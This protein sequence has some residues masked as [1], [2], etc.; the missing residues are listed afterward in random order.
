MSI[1]EKG[2]RVVARVLIDGSD[3]RIVINATV[4]EPASMHF[5]TNH[6]GTIVVLDCEMSN[7]D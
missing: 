4:V 5:L 6:G 3:E 2:D 1:H 7:G